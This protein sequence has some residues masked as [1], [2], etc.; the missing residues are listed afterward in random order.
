MI[1][2][3]NKCP[4]S[5]YRRSFS[6]P[7]HA[8]HYLLLAMAQWSYGKLLRGA[9]TVEEKSPWPDY[10]LRNFSITLPVQAAEAGQ[11]EDRKQGMETNPQTRASS[12]D[13]PLPENSL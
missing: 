1:F 2:I 5:I 3:G 13:C 9:I 10:L 12:A 11:M 7:L 4:E 6:P 8:N